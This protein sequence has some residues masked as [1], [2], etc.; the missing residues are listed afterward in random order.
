MYEVEK[1]K[2][3]MLET[4]PDCCLVYYVMLEFCTMERTDK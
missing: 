4:A 2:A 3:A 1:S